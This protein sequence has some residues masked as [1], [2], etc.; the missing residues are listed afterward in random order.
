MGVEAGALAKYFL[1]QSIGTGIFLVFPLCGGVPVIFGV[2]SSS[3]FL[4]CGLLLKAGVAP[5]HQ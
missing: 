3:I 5:F 4:V 1:A 2:Y